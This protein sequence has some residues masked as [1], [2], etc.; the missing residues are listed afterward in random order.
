MLLLIEI[1]PLSV[2]FAPTMIAYAGAGAKVH[3]LMRLNPPAQGL[4]AAALAVDL[5]PAFHANCVKLGQEH[6]PS[7]I[8]HCPLTRREAFPNPSSCLS[9]GNVELAMGNESGLGGKLNA[10]GFEK[11]GYA[12][13]VASGA[14]KQLSHLFLKDHQSVPHRFTLRIY[15]VLPHYFR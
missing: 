14:E 6:C 7:P 12:H 1:P 8:P 10:I 11:P 3:I 5:S 2:S 9:M 13:L 4:S 15:S